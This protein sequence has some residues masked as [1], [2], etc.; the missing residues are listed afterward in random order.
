LPRNAARPGPSRLLPSLRIAAALSL[1][2][3]AT[4]RPG[5]PGDA[6]LPPGT[7]ASL[8]PATTVAH[9]GPPVPEPPLELARVE[10]QRGDTLLAVLERVGVGAEEAHAAVGSLRAV[11]DLRRLQIGQRL[12]LALDL[13]AGDGA[14]LARLVLPLDPAT[15][16]HLDRAEDGSFA[17]RSVER[18]LRRETVT[19]AV[20]VVDSFYAAGLA[21]DLPPATLAQAIKLLSWDVDFQRDLQPG[22]LMEAVHRRHRNETGELAGEGELE[23]VGLATAG[24]AIEAYR[25]ATPDGSS[26]YYDRTG[27]SLRKWL[28]RTPVDGARLS[29]RFGPRRHPILGYTRMHQGIDFAA[30]T[31]TPVLAAGTGTVEFAGRN[32]SYGNYLRLRHNGGYATAYAHL[33]R[34]AP[35][36]KRGR[37]VEQG[38]V[39]GLVGATGLATGPHLH[40]EVLHQGRQVNPLAVDIAGGEPLQGALLTA[41]LARRDAIDRQRRAAGGLVADGRPE[42]RPPAPL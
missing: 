39:I 38:E 5:D 12:D 19:V 16:I 41:F 30:P 36:M 13:A 11:A 34:F 17:T 4:L 7:V 33:A 40:Y 27:R 3:Y 18:R 32:R 42:N 9:P 24:R 6:T 31:G 14:V 37:R 1:C 2:L 29:S 23:F 35:G 26:E 15:E 10:L 28:L 20:P 8:P 22:D 25:F 21:A